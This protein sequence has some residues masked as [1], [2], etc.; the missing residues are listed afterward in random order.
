MKWNKAED[1]TV[2]DDTCLVYCQYKACKEFDVGYM[3]GEGEWLSEDTHKTIP[4]THWMKLP[5][6]P[7]R[8]ER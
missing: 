4:V 3:S 6:K 8:N 7:K 1:K 2:V 5:P